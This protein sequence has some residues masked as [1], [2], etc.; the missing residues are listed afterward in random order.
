MKRILLAAACVA[1]ASA[2][3]PDIEKTEAPNQVVA[4]FDPSRVPA[5]VPTPNDLAFNPATG[6]LGITPAPDATDADIEFTGY[7]NTLNG[8]P[9]SSTAKATFTGKLDATTVTAA[10][11]RVFDITD[12][13]AV[14]VVADAASAYNDQD[15]E[16]VPAAIEVSRPIGW[17]QGRQYLVAIV[18]GGAGVKGADG[19][20]VVASST[21]NFLRQEGSLVTGC[22]VTDP[23]A[24]L[25]TCRSVT[26]IIPTTETDPAAQ[27]ADRN[28]KAARLEQLRLRYKPLI[29]QMV[30]G[31]VARE[32]LVLLW[33]FT[34]STDVAVVF[35][36]AAATPKVPRPND[37][38]ISRTTGLVTAPIDP[39]ATPAQQE[40]TRDYLNSLNGFPISATATAEIAGGDLDPATVTAANV[41]VLDLTPG[42]TNPVVTA[43]TI[44]YDSTKK[45]IVITPPPGGWTKA[46]QY[47]VALI[48]GKGADGSAIGLLDQAGK[49]IVASQVWALVRAAAPVDELTLVELTSAQIASLTQLQQAYTPL[50]AALTADNNGDGQP[51]LARENIVLGWTFRTLNHPEATFNPDPAAPIIPFPNSLAMKA[52]GGVNLTAPAGSSALVQALIGGLNTL[53]GFSLTAPIVSENSTLEGAFTDR[54]N[55]DPSSLDGGWTIL[56]L[57]GSGL[58][59]LVRA[60]VNCASST[61]TDGG[62]AF[63]LLPDAGTLPAPDALQFVPQAPLSENTTYGVA[64]KTSLKDTTGRS[65]RPVGA[66]ALMRME[67]SLVTGEG[68]NVADPA[69]Y[70]SCRSAVDGVSVQQAIGLEPVRIAHKPFIDALVATGHARKDLALAWTFKTQTVVNG[71]AS[72]P[73]LRQLHDAALGLPSTVDYLSNIT[74]GTPPANV[75]KLYQGSFRSAFLLTNGGTFGG[76]PRVDRIQF[77]LSI[78]TGTALGSGWPVAIFHHG[79]GSSRHESLGIISALGAAGFA[80]ILIDAPFHGDRSS[81][82]GVAATLGQTSDDAAC[83][84]PTQQRCDNAPPINSGTFGFC[85]ARTP[86]VRDAATCTSD[87]DCTAGGLGRCLGDNKCAGGDFLRNAAGKPVF[88]GWNFLNTTNLFITRDNFRQQVVDLGQLARVIKADAATAGSLN[89]RLA[90]GEL[91]DGSQIYYA[92]ISLGGILGSLYVA[93]SPDVHRAVLNVPGADL[94]GILLT[95]PAFTAQRNGFLG[96]LAS[97]GIPQGT[98]NF[99]QF[100]YFARMILDPSDPQNAGY[101]LLNSSVAPADRAVLIQYITDDGVIPN[102]ATDKLIAAATRADAMKRADVFQYGSAANPSPTLAELPFFVPTPSPSFPRHSFLLNGVHPATTS[103]AQSQLANYLDGVQP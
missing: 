47:A 66:F 34:I 56:P 85:I 8:F 55:V 49:S 35:D 50:L 69:T 32:D 52:D 9:A 91:L 67:S 25:T 42:V 6:R 78:P 64:V 19:Q 101:D 45:Q 80:T 54:A 4:R 23:A 59:P 44:S 100:L 79:L 63:I 53:N 5:V 26:N 38:A 73:G 76:A 12:P 48:S 84:N 17:Q 51:D 36:P 14:A 11:V 71:T 98:P 24:D 57:S 77:T 58:P 37:L 86:A 60:C 89:D 90:V 70:A 94:A 102:S 72:Y 81:C 83:A 65:L 46:H 30:R 68:C 29:E 1:V 96:T 13:A 62:V 22:D 92:G 16:Q 31:G 88:S 33:T 75:A 39:A 18:G 93:A 41:R 3:A 95:A 40:F 99:D 43:A 82:A 10:N 2:C 61:P 15:D 20:T 97:V 103:A 21:F 74:P 87:A 7:L 28:A 27:V